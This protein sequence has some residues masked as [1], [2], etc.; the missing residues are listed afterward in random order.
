[1]KNIRFS[2]MFLFGQVVLVATV[3]A[4]MRSPSRLWANAH[5][6]LAFFLICLS[7]LN[8][9]RTT[10]RRR[11]YWVGFS[12]FGSAYFIAI[13]FPW[14]SY[15]VGQ[16]LV[17][18]DALDQIQPLIDS[19]YSPDSPPML[20]VPNTFDSYLYVPPLSSPIQI[21]PFHVIGHSF[22]TIIFASAG[23]FIGQFRFRP[24]ENST[25]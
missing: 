14:L 17:T 9:Y 16:F 4:A 20:L 24:D 8:S 11:A 23:G 18:T 7:I 1:M 12:L 2:L 21:S 22:L 25:T 6:S 13:F 3:L 10:S 5:F 15:H 19:T